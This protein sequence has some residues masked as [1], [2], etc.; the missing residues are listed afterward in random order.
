VI[1]RNRTISRG[2]SPRFASNKNRETLGAMRPV[3]AES[4]MSNP[5]ASFEPHRRRLV[6]LAYR[7]LGSMADAEDAVQE[8]YVRWHEADR[9]NVSNPRAFLMTTTTRI[10][11]DMLKSARSR[12]E[13]YVGPWLPEPVVDTAALAPDSR[14]ELAED[15]SIALLLTLDRLSPLERAAFLLHDV[16]DFSFKEMAAAL[17]RNEAACRQLAARARA[18]VRAARPRGATA[19]M[20]HSG[21]IDAKHAQLLSAFAA[22]TQSGDLN[23][24]KQLLANDVRVITDGGGKVRAAVDVIEGADRVAQFVVNAS[25]P[26]KGQWWREDFTMRF[27]IING[28]PGVIVDAP[29]GPAQTAAFEIEGDV[30]RAL[31]VVRNPDKLRHLAA[32][33]VSHESGAG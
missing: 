26:H 20:A 12:R 1:A 28:L 27:A 17:E 24:L 31:Y 22:A 2:N 29:D 16:F 15:L 4:A 14:T 21:E 33:S 30:I 19:P 7:M 3:N 25:R 6:G 18:H 8:T 13:E 32:P 5:A 11:L 23:R 10:C 9:D